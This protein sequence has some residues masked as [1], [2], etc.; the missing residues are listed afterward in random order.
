MY[1]LKTPHMYYLLEIFKR[2]V[3]GY[4][5]EVAKM[6]GKTAPAGHSWR[7]KMQW[8]YQFCK[9]IIRIIR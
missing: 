8:C 1:L 9:I 2:G 6:L 5:C 7:A 4:H 3:N